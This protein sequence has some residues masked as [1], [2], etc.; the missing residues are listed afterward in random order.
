MTTDQQPRLQ[1]LREGGAAFTEIAEQLGMSVNTVK[2]Y[3][4]RQGIQPKTNDASPAPPTDT[5]CCAHCGKRLVSRTRHEK[6]YCS[7]A[8]RIAW[9]NAHREQLSRKGMVRL[10]CTYCGRAFESYPSQQRKYCGHGCFIAHQHG[11]G[12]VDTSAV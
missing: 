6:R 1:A 7:N 12:D 3:C 8:C 2:S 9:W 11:G 10:A 5:D 4:R